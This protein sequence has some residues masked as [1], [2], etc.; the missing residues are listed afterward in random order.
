MHLRKRPHKSVPLFFL[1]VPYLPLLFSCTF[2][3][4]N[5]FGNMFA[6]V[7]F[8]FVCLSFDEKMG[9]WVAALEGMVVVV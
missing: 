2:H 9:A 7:I 5:I 1:I 3:Y 6:F 8:A 4:R